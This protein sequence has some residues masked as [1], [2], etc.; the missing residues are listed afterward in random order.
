MRRLLIGI[1][2]MYPGAWRGRYGVEFDALMEDVEPDWREVANVLGEA[3]KMQIA[4]G[5]GFVKLAGTMA[6]MGA[7]AALGVSLRLPDRYCS[8]ALLRMTPPKDSAAEANERLQMIEAEILSRNSLAELIQ[9]PSLNLY[10]G[11]RQRMP[12]IDVIE[13]MRHDIQIRRVPAGDG[14]PTTVAISFTYPDL[15]KAEMVTYDLTRKFTETETTVARNRIQVWR[16]AWQEEPPP[17]ETMEVVAGPSDPRNVGR[18]ERPVLMAAGLIAGMLIALTLRWPKPV[19]RLAI[20]SLG[21]VILTYCASLLLPN[22]YTSSAVMRITPPMDPKRW[23]APESGIEH[24]RRMR[25]EILDP[26]AVEQISRSEQLHLTPQERPDVVRRM[27]SGDLRIDIL[28]SQM[29]QISFNYSD[30]ETA[31]RVVRE[32]VTQFLERNII[33]QRAR[34]LTAGPMYRFMAD[35]KLGE[36]LEVLDP[37]SLADAPVWPNRTVIAGIGFAAGFVIGAATLYRRRPRG[38]GLAAAAAAAQ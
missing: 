28:P 13:K 31:Q 8:A 3:V 22:Q 32:I 15:L 11:E 23:S 2:R 14:G 33:E 21:G 38:S 37:A 20:F 6:L 5:R 29:F 16:T 26:A 36:N 10:S 27:R 12:L 25:R 30:G 4:S 34:L 24:V 35:H 17:A 18:P 19:L 1:A 7:L 9:R